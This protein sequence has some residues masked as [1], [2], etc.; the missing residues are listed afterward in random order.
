M[1]KPVIL[2]VIL[3]I[4]CGFQASAQLGMGTGRI[5][6]TVY[7]ETGLPLAGA[8]ITLQNTRYKN[9]LSTTSD[10]KGRWSLVGLASG[11][12]AITV[13]MN[14]YEDKTD[15][16]EYKE[17]TK[18][19]F[20]WDVK[21]RAKGE[22]APAGA[23]AEGSENRVLAGLLETGNKLYADKEYA[24]AVAAYSELLEK[25]PKVYPVYINV[26]NCYR[27]M[28]DY[29]KAF[30]A[31]QTYLDRLT[32]DKGTISAEPVAGTVL[33]SM[34]EMAMAMGSPDKAGESFKQAVASFPTNEMLAFNIGEVYFKQNQAEQAIEYYRLAVRA[35]ETW[36]PPYL[37]LG[38]ACLNK[39][40]YAD[41]LASLKKFLELAPD[42]PQAP[43]IRNL[44]PELEKL[45][46]K[47]PG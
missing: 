14:G 21:L 41:A 5:K 43:T 6:G 37:R 23:A 2:F 39:G 31:Y 7:G 38:Y 44:L 32:A 9:S 25:D 19:A 35:K 42:D 22:A 40:L 18:Q 45:A 26:G 13:T 29:E 15:E 1:K 47:V 8:K 36:A 46:K 11:L 17:V 16:I 34:G 3:L 10:K 33:S 28:P 20:V 30:A 4:G 12:Y 27:E 24:K